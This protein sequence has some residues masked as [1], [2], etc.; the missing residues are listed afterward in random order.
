M[1]YA[2]V[3][4]FPVAIAFCSTESFAK[5]VAP[6]VI[7]FV[8]PIVAKLLNIDTML[9]TDNELLV[10]KFKPVGLNPDTVLNVVSAV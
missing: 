10:D 6:N 4:P 2:K 1:C 3:Q 5:F 9:P 8:V 7:V